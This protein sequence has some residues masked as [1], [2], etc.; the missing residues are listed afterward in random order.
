MIS[1][2]ASKEVQPMC[3]TAASNPSRMVWKKLA[4]PWTVRYR[5]LDT[6]PKPAPM[7]EP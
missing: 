6:R 7:A 4:P 3:I 2:I 5:M 1:T